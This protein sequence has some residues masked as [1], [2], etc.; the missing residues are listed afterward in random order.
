M[1]AGRR[2]PCDAPTMVGDVLSRHY[3]ISPL[4]IAGSRIAPML[5]GHAVDRGLFGEQP[6]HRGSTRDTVGEPAPTSAGEPAM[7]PDLA[8]LERTAGTTDRP[9]GLERVIDKPQ[10]GRLGGRIDTAWD[11]ATQPHPPFPSINVNFTASS[12]HASDSRATSALA[13]SSS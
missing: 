3:R 12:L 2:S 7:D 1:P 13:C 10:Q 6:V 11:T 5:P 9:P 4:G 8:D